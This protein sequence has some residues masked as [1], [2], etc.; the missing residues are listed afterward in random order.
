M[1]Q[2][3]DAIIVSAFLYGLLSALSL[4]MGSIT[5][6]LW[7]PDDHTIAFLMAF[8]GGALLAALT[9]DL[10]AGTVANG[11]YYSLAAGCI[12]G[13]MVFITLNNIINDIGGFLRKASTTVYHLRKQEH[14]K[15]KK[16]L[17]AVK[18]ADVFR[19]LSNENYK[20]LATAIHHRSIKKGTLIFNKGDSPDELY[21]IASGRVAL[22]DPRERIEPTLLLKN[23]DLGWLAFLTGAPYRF[24]ARAVEDTSLWVL[25][26]ATFF[27]LL[28]Q[29]T[30]LTKEVQHWLRNPATSAYLTMHHDIPSENVKLW[31]DRAIHNLLR[32][33]NYS[34][35]VT[36]NHKSQDFR[37][38]AHQIIGCDLFKSLP[39]EEIV[40][41]SDHLVY[42]QFQPGETFYFRGENA[43][44]LFIIEKGHVSMLD[45]LERRSHPYD[46]T[47]RYMF[48]YMPFLTGGNYTMATMAQVQTGAWVLHK[49]DFNQLL[50]VLPELAIQFKAFLQ[51]QSVADHLIERQK[52]SHN[53]TV[54]WIKKSIHQISSKK[55]YSQSIPLALISVTIRV[56]L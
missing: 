8:G 14:R 10:V 2:T 29:S 3:L 26:K 39:A 36:I 47:D 20:V 28:S 5:S 48:G 15:F 38:I 16:I 34:P 22:L 17:S 21:I 54:K 53:D 12:I 7:K 1:F 31:Q 24:T 56:R 30:V 50:L 13:S 51:R 25:P 32:R 45:T 9:L 11:H 18:R 33:N 19:H 37:K 23:D 6:F 42:K 55:T 44:N 4:P 46:L 35:A 43:A 49:K 41:I 52:L 27:A 40:A